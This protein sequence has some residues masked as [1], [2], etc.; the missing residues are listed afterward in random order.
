MMIITHEITMDLSHRGETPKISAV[1]GDCS[2]RQIRFSLCSGGAAWAVPED[3][4]VLVRYRRPDGT[5]GV[6][7]TL[8]DG[9]AAAVLDESAV[10]IAIAPDVLILPGMVRLAVTLTRA[11]QELS[12]FTVLIAVQPN[13][14]ANVTDQGA[15]ISV[16]GL[17][18]APEAEV[19]QYLAVE[20]VSEDGKALSLTAVDAPTGGSGQPGADGKDGADG[21]SAYELAVKNGYEGTEKEWLESLKGQDG[22]DGKDGSDGDPGKDG[23]NGQ[24]G[25]DGKS[26]YEYAV[27]GGYTGTE[28]EFAAKLAE[29]NAKTF[30]VTVNGK[31]SIEENNS[32]DGVSDKTYAELKQAYENGYTLICEFCNEITPEELVVAQLN[33]R[34]DYEDWQCFSFSSASVFQ[35]ELTSTYIDID[36]DD[37]VHIYMETL[38]SPAALTIGEVSYDGSAAVDMTD[39]INALVAEALTEESELALSD[40]LFDKSTA[41]VGQVFYHSSSGPTMLDSASGF[42]SYVP[43]R[44]AGTYRFLVDVKIHGETYALR[45]PLVTED[46]TFLRNAS[47]TILDG[48]DIKQTLVEVEITED[49]ITGGAVYLCYDGDSAYLDTLMIVKDRDY[50]TEYIA[51]LVVS[52]EDSEDLKQDNGLFGK[53]ALFLGDSICAGTTVGEDSESYGYGWAGLI[54]EENH[55]TW[56]NYG[57]NGGTIV[58]VESVAEERWLTTQMSLA[59]TEHAAADFV[60]FEGGCNDADILGED[61]LGEISDDFTTFDT[62]TFSGAMESLILGLLTNWPDAKL[63]YIVAQKMGNAPYTSAGSLRRRYFDRAVEICEKWGIPVLDLWKTSPLNPAVSLHYNSALTAEEALTAGVYYTDGQHLTQMGYNRITP[64]IEAFMRCL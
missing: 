14:S 2:T 28:A 36:M 58:S 15:Y 63:G 54:G 13:F 4:A 16:A 17:L 20:S 8:P 27:A 31:V 7:D 11:E 19:G 35:G 5:D 44:G 21:A 57:R 48:S 38:S 29:E 61:G 30:C 1:Q 51:Y 9:S 32:F 26:A 12:T 49:D 45:I 53:T 47:A 40:N 24:D 42:Y 43:L 39:T 25:T 52:A 41:T 23:E 46:K 34:Y 56:G 55:M 64:Q 10:T 3:A 59:L 18:P 37:T 50:P 62:A 6:Y 33:L 60:I 22:E